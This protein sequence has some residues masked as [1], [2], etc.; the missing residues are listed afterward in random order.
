MRFDDY[1]GF[2]RRIIVSQ[3]WTTNSRVRDPVAALARASAGLYESSDKRTA[4]GSRADP[5]RR[6][7]SQIMNKS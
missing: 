7:M 2:V 5:F 1:P 6:L 3:Q 4:E